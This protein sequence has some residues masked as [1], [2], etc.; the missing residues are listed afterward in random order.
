MLLWQGLRKNKMGCDYILCAQHT[1]HGT[2]RYSGNPKTC[3]CGKDQR[4]K[5]LAYLKGYRA[6]RVEERKNSNS[7]K[8]YLVSNSLI[9][10]TLFQLNFFSF[11]FLLSNYEQLPAHPPYWQ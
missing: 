2:C 4:E 10:L 1:I 5:R 8:I 11:T 6:G 9:I 3:A 7:P